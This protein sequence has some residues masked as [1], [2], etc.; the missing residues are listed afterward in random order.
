MFQDSP[1]ARGKNLAVNFK[2]GEMMI[3]RDKVDYSLLMHQAGTLHEVTATNQVMLSS[4][5]D[6]SSK[7]YIECK[8][9][10]I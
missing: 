8:T 4:S 5:I 1:S 7:E 6:I 10:N 3:V 2:Q 9:Y